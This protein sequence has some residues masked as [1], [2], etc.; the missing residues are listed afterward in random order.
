MQHDSDQV[1]VPPIRPLRVHQRVARSLVFGLL[2]MLCLTSVSC[3]TISEED[4]WVFGLS[5][6]IYSSGDGDNKYG[7]ADGPG[8]VNNVGLLILVALP[9]ILDIA[10]LPITLTHDCIVGDR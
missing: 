10:F 7:D 8:S 2:A 6:A 9:L 3:V 4:A 5:R 1:V